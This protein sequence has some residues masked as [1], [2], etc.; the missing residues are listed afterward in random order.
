MDEKNF[1]STHRPVHQ[2][3]RLGET[4]RTVYRTPAA[5][6]I[7]TFYCQANVVSNTF[8]VILSDS[9]GLL[10]DQQTVGHPGK[11][12]PSRSDQQGAHAD[13]VQHVPRY[14]VRVNRVEQRARP[15]F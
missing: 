13:R 11:M 2:S 3:K 5:E 15:E 7:Q 9:V 4:L 6:I 10:S 12:F 8:H 1:L 14:L